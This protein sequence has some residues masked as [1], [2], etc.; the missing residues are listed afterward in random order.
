[1]FAEATLRPQ[2]SPLFPREVSTI[3]IVDDEAEIAD[4]LAFHLQRQGFL[5]L[6]ADTG[7]GGLALARTE[8]PSLVLLD[9]HLPDADGFSVCE[10]LDLDPMT[11]HI[12]VIILSGMERPDMIRRAR[13]AGCTY[14]VRKPYDPNALL[15]LVQQA[16]RESRGVDFE[17]LT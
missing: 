11:C 1:M 5:T 4:A 6:V 3:L 15:I 16:L 14:F 7:A 13:S 9:V 12:P 17:S 8:R 10:E 2:C